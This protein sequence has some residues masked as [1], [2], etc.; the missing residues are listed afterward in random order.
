MKF[1]GGFC[2]DGGGVDFCCVS[3]KITIDLHPSRDPD[4][5]QAGRP[6]S[7]DPA[8]GVNDQASTPCLDPGGSRPT[9]ARQGSRDRRQAGKQEGRKKLSAAF[10]AAAAAAGYPRQAGG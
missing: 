6:G 3:Q 5:R 2:A 7:R 8:A 1:Y 9:E 10:R 4:R